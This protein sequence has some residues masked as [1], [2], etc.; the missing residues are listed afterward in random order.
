MEKKEIYEKPTLEKQKKM[1]FMFDAL[2]AKCVEGKQDI[3][4]STSCRHHSQL[5]CRQCS[6]CHSCR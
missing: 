3:N 6:S 5:G 1:T 4:C 2:I